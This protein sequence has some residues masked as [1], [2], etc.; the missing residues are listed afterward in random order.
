MIFLHIDRCGGTTIEKAFGFREG[1]EVIQ[2]HYTLKE[3]IKYYNI[4][5]EKIKRYFIWGIVRNP[6][7]KVVSHYFHKRQNFF[8]RGE[9]RLNRID[10]KIAQAYDFNDWL[11]IVYHNLDFFGKK[12]FSNQIDWFN[13]DGINYSDKIIRFENYQDVQIIIN[14]FG[15]KNAL[16]KNNTS[17]HKNYRSYYND[18]SREYIKKNF[19][20]D[21]KIFNYKF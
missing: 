7:D 6:F 11:K 3:I 9:G 14:R 4:D 15:A 2:E 19:A 12:H 16:I 5:P 20:I 18:E 21:L 13:Y 1:Q 8:N 17:N 10:I